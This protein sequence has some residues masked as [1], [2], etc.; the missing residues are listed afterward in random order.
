MSTVIRPEVSKKNKYWISRHRYYELKH[1][2]LQYNEWKKLYLE[3][4]P[5]IQ[6]PKISRVKILENVSDPVGD[7]AVKRA[8]L[9]G[10]MQLVEETAICTDRELYSYILAAVTEGR[11]YTYL[12]TVMDIPCGK[13]YFYER[14]RKFFWLLSKSR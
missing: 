13:D 12:R 4:V 2:C 6:I 10:K 1:F 5:R 14:Y 11:P 7:L 9:A 8:E 3:T